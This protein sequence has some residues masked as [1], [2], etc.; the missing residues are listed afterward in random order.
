MKIKQQF[1][2]LVM[3]DVEI[4]YLAQFNELLRYVFQV[5]TSE[6]DALG[7]KPKEMEQEKRP[8]LEKASVLGWFDND[9]LISQ[10]AVYPMQVNI[11]G[12]IFNMGGVTGVGT[13]PEYA[14]FGLAKKL[15]AQALKE[16]IDRKQTISYLYPYS[17]PY[18]RK[19][20][21]EIISDKMSF[22]IA[23][24]QLPMLSE[25]PGMMRRV[26]VEHQDLYDVYNNYATC[27]HGAMIRGQLEWM[28]YWRW[29]SDDLIAA[30]YYDKDETPKGY[31]LYFIE[32]DEFKV[33]EIVYLT[34]EAR[35]GIWNYI[36]AHRSMVTTVTGHQYKL[37]PLAFLLEDGEISE[38][39]KPYFMARIVDV[40]NF[41]KQFPFKEINDSICFKVTDPLIEQNCDYF[42]LS[43]N[44]KIPTISKGQ[45][46]KNIVECDIQTLTTMLMNYRRPQYLQHIERLYADL[47]VIGLLELTI[48]D[49]NIYF[50]DYF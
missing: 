15:I 38:Q 42:T 9:K 25:V 26:D 20:G 41:L 27:H 48:P 39:I 43:F 2:N 21:W 35:T 23:D 37:E 32:N 22:S 36:S 13:Y 18:Y 3:Q 7:W 10:I 12:K 30:I 33:K 46:Q 17:I 29:D 50:S 31:L 5:T 24:H 19:K 40:E 8:V 6:L 1:K 49:N 47:H 4:E 28:E 34:Q 45:K 14:S 16:M 11:H 44:N